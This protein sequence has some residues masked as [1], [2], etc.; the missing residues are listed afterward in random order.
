MSLATLEESKAYVEDGTIA[1]QQNKAEGVID[2]YSRYSELRNIASEEEFVGW[3]NKYRSTVVSV[4]VSADRV[5]ECPVCGIMMVLEQVN[6]AV[7]RCAQVDGKYI[8]PHSTLPSLLAA[9]TSKQSKF[10]GCMMPLVFDQDDNVLFVP[11][12]KYAGNT[13]HFY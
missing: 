8:N 6:C 13:P 11:L 5:T 3:W 10:V 1:Y 4:P 7:F 9:K 2:E 12:D